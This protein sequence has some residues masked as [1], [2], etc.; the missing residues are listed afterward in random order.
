M[1]IMATLVREHVCISRMLIKRPIFNNLSLKGTSTYFLVT[2]LCFWSVVFCSYVDSS[3][4][5]VCVRKREG[6]KKVSPPHPP[7]LLYSER[8]KTVV[9]WS[10]VHSTLIF[11]PSLM[12]FKVIKWKNGNKYT[13]TKEKNYQDVNLH[14]WLYF[15]NLS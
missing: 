7:L 14:F 13:I 11:L 4:V 2:F 15:S 6:E 12:K 9:W 10:H 5:F 8:L 3:F 1:R